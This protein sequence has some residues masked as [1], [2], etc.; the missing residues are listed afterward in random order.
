MADIRVLIAD[1]HAVVRHGLRLFLDL[2]EGISVVGEASD[3]GEAV[4]QAEA[5]EPDVVLMDLVMPRMDGVEAARRVK[6]ARPATKVLVLTSFAD[7]D[8]LVP[9]IEAGASGYVMKDVAPEQLADAVRRIH[10]GEPYLHPD[11]ARR[12]LELMAEGRREPQGTVTILFTDIEES[13]PIVE[14]LGDRAALDV[15]RDHDRILRAALAA[16]GGV[17]VTHTGDGLM[18]AFPSA[19]RAVAC[20]VAMQRALAE[21]N[22]WN[23]DVPVRVR[24]GLN[25]GDVIAEEHRYFGEAVFIAARVSESAR[26]GQI[27]VSEATKALGAADGLRFV[28]LG[29]HELK[30]IRSPQRLYEVA[31]E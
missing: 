30:G 26:G 25:T 16:H 11:V 9:V 21:H 28:E 2:Q 18:A 17:E 31:W 1:D 6:A 7:D 12:L 13:T 22:L 19:R 29:E 5:L 15:F 8:K 10:R 3:G 24:M 4:A 14:R 20:A 27:L 23:R